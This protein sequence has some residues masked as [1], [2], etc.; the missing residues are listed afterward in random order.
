MELS[1]ALGINIRNYNANDI[2]AGKLWRIT[3]KVDGVRRLFYKDNA[4]KVRCYSRTGKTDPWLTHIASYLERDRFP[5]DYIYDTEL[6]DA[7][8]YFSKKESYI[9]RTISA[10]K[11][12]QQFI[13]NKKDLVAICFDMFRPNGDLTK[14][15]QRHILLTET[16]AESPLGAPIFQ[17]PFYGILDGNDLGLLAY[18]MRRVTSQNKEG[19]ML[20]NLDAPYIH[21]RSKEL[22]KVKRIEEFIGKVVDIEL[23]TADT[24]I[25]GGIAALICEVPECTVPVR[26]GSGFTDEERVY[27]AKNSPIGNLIEIEA[28]S[29]TKA[30]NGRV[31]LSMPIFKRALGLPYDTNKDVVIP[32][33]DK[34]KDI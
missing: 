19:L 9:V 33:L 11:A 17:V 10:G 34:G 23:A 7:N 27:F 16:F 32:N 28:F 21:G 8:S 13:K 31:S 14:G 18:L 26:V 15:E 22:I 5:K 4:G 1:P 12:S 24:K 25:A 3:E 29:K 2:L 30:K 6:V 20:M